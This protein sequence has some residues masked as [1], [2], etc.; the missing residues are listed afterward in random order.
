MKQNAGVGFVYHLIRKRMTH[1]NSKGQFIS[2]KFKLPPDFIALKF[3]KRNAEF[4]ALTVF[5]NLTED[6][7]LGKDIFKRLDTLE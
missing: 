3:T 7:E 1:L 4:T 5:A 2:D 6:I